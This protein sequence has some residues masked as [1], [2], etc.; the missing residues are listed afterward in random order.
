[1][2]VVRGQ[3]AYASLTSDHIIT[4][5]FVVLFEEFTV[6]SV[7]FGDPNGFIDGLCIVY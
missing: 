2:F 4:F 6:H 1:M 5:N 7:C 3:K